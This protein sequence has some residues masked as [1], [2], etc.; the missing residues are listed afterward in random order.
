MVKGYVPPPEVR[1]FPEYLRAAGWYATNNVKTDYQFKPP[2]TAWDES[3][4]K[5]HWRN[6]KPG[7]PFFAVFNCNFTHANLYDRRP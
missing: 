4:G 1:C 3:S 7:Q 5:A 6:R 2:P